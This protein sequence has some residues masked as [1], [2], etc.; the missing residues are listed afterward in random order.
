M[1]AIDWI[2]T[3]VCGQNPTHTWAPG[4]EILPCCQR[5]T[6]LYAGVFFAAALHLLL[7][8][9]LTG[10]FL[11]IHGLFL[12]LMV[13]FGYHW[14][15]QGPILR[16][17]TGLLFGAGLVTFLMVSLKTSGQSPAGNSATPGRLYFV[18]LAFAGALALVLAASTWQGASLLLTAFATMGAFIL[19]TLLCVTTAHYASALWRMARSR[20]RGRKAGSADAIGHLSTAVNRDEPSPGS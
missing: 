6:G 19:F 10:R 9:R 7:R 12:L 16:T 5:C 11:E 15:P 20:W 1:T 8:P 13:P 14:L 2:F 4:G 17:V 3:A 18:G